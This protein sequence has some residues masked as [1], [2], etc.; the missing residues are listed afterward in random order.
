LGLKVCSIVSDAWQE[1][2]KKYCQPQQYMHSGWSP[3]TF[4]DR[5]TLPAKR[6]LN[7]L[8]LKINNIWVVTWC[9]NILRGTAVHAR[10]MINYPESHVG[11]FLCKTY[12]MDYIKGDSFRLTEQL[13]QRA[14][15]GII[16]IC[17]FDVPHRCKGLIEILL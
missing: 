17:W 14:A 7:L 11:H 12:L 9:D 8:F 13:I 15:L 6:H 1:T 4:A 3:I 2:I 5:S 10:K 16:W